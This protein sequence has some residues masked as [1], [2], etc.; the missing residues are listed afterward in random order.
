M[1]KLYFAPLKKSFDKYRV[2]GPEISVVP[3]ILGENA[4]LQGVSMIVLQQ[5]LTR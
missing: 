4:A 1:G 2:E 5:V 3:A